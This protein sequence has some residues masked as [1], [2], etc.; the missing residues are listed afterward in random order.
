M[1][2]TTGRSKLVGSLKDL[3][4]KWEKTRESWSD[5]VSQDMEL[6]VLSPLDP[7]VRAAATAMEKIGEL[8]AKARRD[9]E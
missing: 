7:K 3:L 8:L 6:K 5:P 9:C 4:V 1:S 2:L